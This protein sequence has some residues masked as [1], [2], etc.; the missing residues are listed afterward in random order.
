[1]TENAASS[2]G[3][4]FNFHGLQVQPAASNEASHD[5]RV[6]FIKR[7]RKN[8]KWSGWIALDRLEF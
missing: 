8:G 5:A 7:E 3:A 1:M 4:L 2:R 6:V